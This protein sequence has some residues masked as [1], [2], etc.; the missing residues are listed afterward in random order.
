[1]TADA[2]P[3]A[4][5]LALVEQLRQENRTLRAL[6]AELEQRVAELSAENQAL[7]DQLDEAQ[8]QAARQAAPFRRRDSQRPVVPRDIPASIVLCRRK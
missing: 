6:I 2:Q 1:M 3:L 8:R 4:D 5:T 7:H